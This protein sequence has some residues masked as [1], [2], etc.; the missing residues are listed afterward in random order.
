MDHAAAQMVKRLNHKFTPFQQGQKV[1]LEMKHHSDRYPFRKLA[2][3]QHGPF[4]IHK[5]LSRLVYQLTLPKHMKIHSVFHASLLSPYH[6][7]EPH[8]PNYFDTPPE[9]VD[10][11]DKYEPEAILAHKPWYRSMA[12]LIRWK[13]C[14]TAE[15]SW[16]P[17]WHLK[18]AQEMLQEYKNKHTIGKNSRNP[19][20]QST[21]TQPTWTQSTSASN[22]LIMPKSL[23]NPPTLLKP[24]NPGKKEPRTPTSST[25]TLM[26]DQPRMPSL[27]RANLPYQ[28]SLDLRSRP[29]RNG[30]GIWKKRDGENSK[31]TPKSS[32]RSED[33]QNKTET[34]LTDSGTS[35]TFPNQPSRYG[36][37]SKICLPARYLSTT[38]IGPGNYDESATWFSNCSP[39]PRPTPR[40]LSCEGPMQFRPLNAS[41]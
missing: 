35:S 21:S 28:T 41:K 39:E 8:G 15:N 25:L 40:M 5:V 12:Y 6:E 23:S 22:S 4:K 20:T 36:L 29:R 30:F 37:H 19:P 24:T 13:N 3:K 10:D 27:S 14:S 1:W 34:A 17:E 2:P 32:E 11:H 16:E 18:N 7:T 33:A 9:I 31:P 38:Q 26:G